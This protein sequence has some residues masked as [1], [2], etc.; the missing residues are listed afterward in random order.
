MYYDKCILLGEVSVISSGSTFK[1]RVNMGILKKKS[2][3]KGDL[4]ILYVTTC[5]DIE[6]SFE[7]SRRF[8]E[9][10]IMGKI[11]S[12]DKESMDDRY[13]V[14]C[15]ADIREDKYKAGLYADEA[16]VSVNSPFLLTQEEFEQY[17]GDDE[18]RHKYLNEVSDAV[19]GFS[20]AKR[21]KNWQNEV[22]KI[23]LGLGVDDA[24]NIVEDI[25]EDFNP[26]R[27]IVVRFPS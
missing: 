10:Q 1:R 17:S 11:H 21:L 6:T 8:L 19:L 14:R 9:C 16:L 4:A 3:K 23:L 18:L 24:W 2:F 12:L 25:R 7:H 13:I 15:S 27:M 5:S 20:I 22:C 26:E